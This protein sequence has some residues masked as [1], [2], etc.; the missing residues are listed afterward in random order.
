MSNTVQHPDASAAHTCNATGCTVLV[1]AES[2]MCQPHWAMVPAALRDT[3]KTH[4][5]PG[6]AITESPSAQYVDIATAAIAAVDHKESRVAARK[7][8][9]SSKPVQLRLFD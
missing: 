7:P 4:Y 6:Q 1:A 8:R 2:F 9:R 5:Q 3:I